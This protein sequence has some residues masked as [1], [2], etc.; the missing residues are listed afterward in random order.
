MVWTALVFALVVPATSGVAAPLEVERVPVAAAAVRQE[1]VVPSPAAVPAVEA[2]TDAADEAEAP[3]SELIDV[4]LAAPN[5]EAA[6][7]PPPQCFRDKDC[8]QICGK[9]NGVCVRV[10]SCYRA[11]YCAS[12]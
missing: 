3:A 6:C 5:A 7:S 1:A 8:D 12:Y 11:C 4:S 10:N 9:G 2:K